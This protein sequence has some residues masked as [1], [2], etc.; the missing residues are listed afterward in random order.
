MIA[1]MQDEINSLKKSKKNPTLLAPKK[2]VAKKKKTLGN[3]MNRGEVSLGN[4]II[5]F[6]NEAS[7]ML[8]YFHRLF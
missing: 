6:L 4:C 5:A 7:L 1:N 8:I 3:L 2:S